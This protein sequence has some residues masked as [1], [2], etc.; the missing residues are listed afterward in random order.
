MGIV[1]LFSTEAR[2]R[3]IVR[4]DH[5]SRGHVNRRA[6]EVNTTET[7]S[8]KTKS[9]KSCT[10][11]EGNFKS[12]KSCKE[13]FG[14]DGEDLDGIEGRMGNNDDEF[15]FTV[16]D[17][18]EDENGDIVMTGH[19]NQDQDESNEESMSSTKGLYCTFIAA[20]A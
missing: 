12:T 1:S 18:S 8:K 13:A 17:I 5:I 16:T 20:F 15:E 19:M 11:A 7:P 2:R 14:D 9:A 10:D 6:E 3:K 4:G